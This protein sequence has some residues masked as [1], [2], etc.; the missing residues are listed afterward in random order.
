[1]NTA[2]VLITNFLKLAA[3]IKEGK[4][5]FDQIPFGDILNMV[6]EMYDIRPGNGSF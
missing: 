1:M 3:Y 4:V 5:A 2:E 6:Q